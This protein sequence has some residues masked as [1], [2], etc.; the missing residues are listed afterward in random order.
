MEIQESFFCF[1]FQVSG[2]KFQVLS[3]KAG[4]CFAS[5]LSLV[6]YFDFVFLRNDKTV[7]ENYFLR[8]NTEDTEWD[9]FAMVIFL[10]QRN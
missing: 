6:S 8:E 4:D 2:F 9:C 7:T 1:K 3:A 5:S 10:P